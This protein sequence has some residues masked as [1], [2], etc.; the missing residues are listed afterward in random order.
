V[1]WNI[2]SGVAAYWATDAATQ[3]TNHSNVAPMDWDLAKWSEYK[4][5]FKGPYSR[6]AI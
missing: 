2:I 5:P 1:Q 6:N 4:E 3:V